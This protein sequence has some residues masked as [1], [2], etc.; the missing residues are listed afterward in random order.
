MAYQIPGEI[1]DL[2][3]LSSAMT[4]IL[5]EL[6][7]GEDLTNEMTALARLTDEAASLHERFTRDM[8]TETN[9]ATA[10]FEEAASIVAQAMR[11][12]LAGMEGM[13]TAAASVKHEAESTR[14]ENAA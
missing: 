9:K 11:S 14:G 4:G 6:G 10:A 7:A 8:G 13:A 12:V 3:T 2:A 5:E 1:P